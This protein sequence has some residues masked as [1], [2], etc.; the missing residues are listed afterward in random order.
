[1]NSNFVQD[2]LKAHKFVRDRLS[3]LACNVHSAL[4]QIHQELVYH[5]HPIVIARKSRNG[6]S[7]TKNDQYIGRYL[8]SGTSL[9][10]QFTAIDYQLITQ[11]WSCFNKLSNF[12]VLKQIRANLV[13]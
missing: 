3:S 7:S 8:F 5:I 9:P 10:F 1:M 2:P 13:S 4:H 6:Q 12:T 11:F